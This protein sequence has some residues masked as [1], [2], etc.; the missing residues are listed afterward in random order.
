M[1]KRGD[2]GRLACLPP[3]GLTPISMDS[4][5]STGRS[6]SRSFKY[7]RRNAEAPPFISTVMKAKMNV[8][9]RMTCGTVAMTLVGQLRAIA[10]V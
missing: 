1:D 9:V 7:S 4:C 6:H 2:G 3:S 5:S 10:T 8:A